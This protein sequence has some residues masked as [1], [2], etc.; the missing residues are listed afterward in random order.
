MQRRDRR[1]GGRA[2]ASVPLLSPSSSSGRTPARVAPASAASP[3]SS[4]PASSSRSSCSTSAACGRR[5]LLCVVDEQRVEVERVG[6]QEVA[7]SVASNRQ[8]IQG[9]GILVLQSQLHVLRN[10]HRATRT[11]EAEQRGRMSACA[12]RHRP[13]VSR[14]TAQS[15]LAVHVCYWWCRR[16]RCA[17]ACIVLHRLALAV[18]CCVD[19]EMRVHGYIDPCDG[20]M[21][22]RSILQLKRHRLAGELHQKSDRENATDQSNERIKPVSTGKASDDAAKAERARAAARLP[23]VRQRRWMHQPHQRHRIQS[24]RHRVTCALSCGRAA[25]F[26]GSCGA[27]RGA[28]EERVRP[29]S[30]ARSH[31]GVRAV[32]LT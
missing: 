21:H 6:Q 4:S 14:S 7:N 22:H 23:E 16:L 30:C 28:S 3:A 29:A 26:A 2:E 5:F 17:I 15:P 20:S 12:E 9:S 10:T 8:R 18:L 31:C 24:T 19:L 27:R 13:M 32:G 1:G 11:A 25:R